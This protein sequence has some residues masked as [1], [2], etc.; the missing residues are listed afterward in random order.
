MVSTMMTLIS[1]L[2]RGN[3]DAFPSDLQKDHKIGRHE[4]QHLAVVRNNLNMNCFTDWQKK[5]ND[6]GSDIIISTNIIISILIG[7][8]VVTLVRAIIY[9]ST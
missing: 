1:F 7:V 9:P 5:H 3:V 4:A 6:D 2:L 8:I